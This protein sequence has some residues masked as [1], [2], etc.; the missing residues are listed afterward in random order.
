MPVPK[1]A[2]LGGYEISARTEDRDNGGV[3]ASFEVA[4]YRPVEFEVHAESDRPSYVRGDDAKWIAH[5]DFLFGAPMT[6]ATSHTTVT[7]EETTFS[8]DNTD[9]FETSDAAYDQDLPDTTPRQAVVASGNAKLDTKGATET[10]G[11]LA[12]PGQRGPEAVTCAV[13]VTDL[14]RQVVSTSTTAIVHPADYYVG[15]KLDDTFVDA[16]TTLK[17]TFIAVTPKG[18]RLDG[19]RLAVTLLKRKWVVSKEAK[20]DSGVSTTASVVDT[21]TGN[22]TIT[23]SAR[24]AACDLKTTDGGYY[25]LR[26]TG[27]DARG[28][29]VAAAI[30]IYAMG[31]GGGGWFESDKTEV[32]LVADKQAYAVGD[33]ARILVKSPFANADAL[34]T[35]ER[36]GIYDKHVVALSGGTP[37]IEVPITEEMRPN[38]YVSVVLTRGRTKPAPA[39]PNAVDAG[40]PAYRIGFANLA[41]DPAKKRLDVAVKPSKTD[42]KPGED[43]SVDVDVKDATG[44]PA[45]AEVTLYAVDE[46]VLSLI[47]YKTPDPLRVFAEP[48]E[49]KVATLESRSRLVALFD[50]LSGLG[51]DKG[52]AGGGGG[53]PSAGGTSRHDFRASAYFNPNVVTDEKGHASVSFKLPDAVTTYRVMAVVATADDR[54]GYAEKRVTTS[55]PLMARP[56]LP[57]FLRAGDTLDAGVIVTSKGVAGD[58]DVSLKATGITT[59]GPTSA[60]VHLDA[61]ESKEVRFAM[62]AHDIGT[63]TFHFDARGGGA[64]DSVDVTREVHVPMTLETVALSGTTSGEAVEKLGDLGGIRPDTGELT[65]TTSSSAL[66][67]LDGAADQLLDYPYGCSE[68][69]TSRLVPIV[70]MRSLASDFHLKMPANV[71]D[72]VATTVA[73][74]LKHQR[75]D[76][77]FGLWPDSPESDIWVT[78]YVYM[79]LKQAEASGVTIPAAVFEGAGQYM[80][81]D[82]DELRFASLRAGRAGLRDGR[83]RAI[84]QARSGA[85]LASLRSAK[86]SAPLCESAPSPRDGLCKERRDEHRHALARGRE[87]PPPR[88]PDR[89]G[90]RERR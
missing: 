30:D 32:S 84:R 64:N 31:A 58:I 28:N 52:L 53:A 11:K 15:I 45:K 29:E 85:H 86:R 61:G 7:R 34:V 80:R 74:I 62:E 73:Q 41:I 6:G 71:D 10:R 65:V 13:D 55:Q 90:D 60:R 23:S 88:R 24:G 70:T 77:G 54:F 43:V 79:G 89:K 51:G 39:Q 40:A 4:E 67:G 36:G 19:Q 26:A 27:K 8:P 9:G 21:P 75:G 63:A 12:L 49:L 59:I 3:N 76:G 66:V 14:S 42:L 22:C 68:Q 5:G 2:A 57:R 17:P 48:R 20:G 87:L 1:T 72:V 82:L 81:G 38:A 56:E 69:L 33:K 46:G 18:E 37:T 78:A 35:V 83:P 47:H 44:K 50:P 16:G 25:I